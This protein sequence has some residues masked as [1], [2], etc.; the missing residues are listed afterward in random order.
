MYFLQ[1]NWEEA[2]KY[3][4]LAIK[5]STSPNDSMMFYGNRAAAYD[6]LGDTDNTIADLTKYLELDQSDSEYARNACDRINYLSMTKSTNLFSLFFS[7]L[8]LPCTR[9]DSDY[10]TYGNNAYEQPNE[11]CGS[12]YTEYE[13]AWIDQIQRGGTAP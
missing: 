5:A 1:E 3:Y 9:F 4:S 6:Q 10:E 12:G 8:T 11:P 13:C 7:A 2:I